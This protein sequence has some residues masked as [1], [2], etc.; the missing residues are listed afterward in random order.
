[1][2]SNFERLV[3]AVRQQFGHLSYPNQKSIV[4][5]FGTTPIEA[6]LEAIRLGYVSPFFAKRDGVI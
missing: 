1:M 5:A 3:A 4:A 2:S 6:A